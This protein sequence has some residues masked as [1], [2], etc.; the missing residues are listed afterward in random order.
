MEAL[1]NNTTEGEEEVRDF[2]SIGRRLAEE[3]TEQVRMQF[4]ILGA[5]TIEQLAFWNGY[6]SKFEG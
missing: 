2:F 3:F 1:E 4:L 5:T 6:K